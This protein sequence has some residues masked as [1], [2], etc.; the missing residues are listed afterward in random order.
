MTSTRTDGIDNVD[1]DTQM[2]ITALLASATEDKMPRVD[3]PAPIRAYLDNELK[4][5]DVRNNRFRRTMHIE[6]DALALGVLANRKSDQ[7]L[8]GYELHEAA[9]KELARQIRQYGADHDRPVAIERNGAEVTFR[10]A[11]HR[12]TSPNGEVTVTN[13]A[14]AAE[15]SKAGAESAANEA[16]KSAAGK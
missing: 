13:V 6:S 8:T 11:K 12:E 15:E 9:A 2:D 5:F 16:V 14:D 10:I 7:K 4:T 1:L 3:V